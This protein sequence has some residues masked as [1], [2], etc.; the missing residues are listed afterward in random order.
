MENNRQDAYIR[1][2]ENSYPATTLDLNSR[3][4]QLRSDIAGLKGKKA[5]ISFKLPDSNTWLASS[6]LVTSESYDSEGRTMLKADLRGLSEP[7]RLKLLQ[8][9]SLSLG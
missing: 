9:E 5:L 1:F 7:L 2:R 8:V 6:V 3:E 4:I